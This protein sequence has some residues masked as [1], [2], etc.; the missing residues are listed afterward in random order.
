MKANIYILHDLDFF[1]ASEAAG[2]FFLKDF[3]NSC[4]TGISG[5]LLA[6]RN[7][8]INKPSTYLV[9]V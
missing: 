9:F 7:V 6:F 1:L 8:Y 4:L 3:L 5:S 2:P